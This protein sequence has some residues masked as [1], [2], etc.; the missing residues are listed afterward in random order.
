MPKR[1]VSEVLDHALRGA[2]IGGTRVFA[3]LGN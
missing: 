1:K 2:E 3:E